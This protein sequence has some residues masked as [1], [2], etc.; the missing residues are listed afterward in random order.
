[1]YK[2]ATERRVLLLGP[3]NRVVVNVEPVHPMGI[4]NS[5]DS[6]L[7]KPTG[8]QGSLFRERLHCCRDSKCV[9]KRNIVAGWRLVVRSKAGTLHGRGRDQWFSV[10]VSSQP[11]GGSAWHPSGA[12]G[13][14]RVMRTMLV[15]SPRRRLKAPEGSFRPR[16]AERHSLGAKGPMMRPLLLR[17]KRPKRS[18]LLFVTD[19]IAASH[20]PSALPKTARRRSSILTPHLYRYIFFAVRCIRTRARN[21]ASGGENNRSGII[22]NLP[23]RLASR[24]PA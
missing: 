8:N 16:C 1:M 4:V 13:S 17:G 21:M 14:V 12:G 15:K 6:L 7:E 5:H 19:D 23:A 24:R 9:L 11:V 22:R 3:N 18:K 2:L 10:E 20:H